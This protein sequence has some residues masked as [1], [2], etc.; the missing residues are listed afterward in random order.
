MRKSRVA[1]SA[2]SPQPSPGSSAK[3]VTST[4]CGSATTID[5]PPGV[6]TVDQAV[7]CSSSTA[8]SGPQPWSAYSSLPGPAS[9]RAPPDRDAQLRLSATSTRTA[10]A[11]TVTSSTARS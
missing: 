6:A 10:P 4:A 11:G 1:E 3:S 7:L 9:A 8:A 5:L 2:S